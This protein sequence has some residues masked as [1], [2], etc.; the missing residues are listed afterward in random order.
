MKIFT[1]TCPIFTFT[2]PCLM[3]RNIY[4]CVEVSPRTTDVEIGVCFNSTTLAYSFST[5]ISGCTAV[6]ARNVLG[7]TGME[8]L[9][10]V[11]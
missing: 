10:Q 6:T 4:L 1:F 7:K 3:R 9:K 8:L 5:M 2:C 11:V